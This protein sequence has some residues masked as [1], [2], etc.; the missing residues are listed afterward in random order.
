MTE[1]PIGGV[2]P[3]CVNSATPFEVATLVMSDDDELS[4][5]AVKVPD[6]PVAFSDVSN[7]QSESSIL[8]RFP[9]NTT[10]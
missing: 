1:L 5:I 4:A 2:V 7:N 10:F 6:S 3:A 8:I 9:V